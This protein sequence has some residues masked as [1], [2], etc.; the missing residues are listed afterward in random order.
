MLWVVVVGFLCV[1]VG[2]GFWWLL[3]WGLWV[4]GLCGVLVVGWFGVVGLVWWGLGGGDVVGFGL[5]VFV[6]FVFLG[7]GLGCFGGCCG[8]IGV[9]G[10]VGG[11]GFFCGGGVYCGVACVTVVGVWVS[12]R[13]W[14]GGGFCGGGFGVGVFG[15]VFFG[16]GLVWF[17]G[18]CVVFVGLL[19]F[20]FGWVVGC[21]DVGR[22]ESTDVSTAGYQCF[23]IH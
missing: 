23:W 4:L 2:L 14:G 11:C 16:L 18:C 1:F 20:C 21:G 9:C 6:L 7:G 10:G 19:V 13:G 22:R 17:F 15:G 5:G 8:V 3:W 12:V